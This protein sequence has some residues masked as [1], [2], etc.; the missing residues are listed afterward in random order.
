MFKNIFSEKEPRVDLALPEVLKTVSQKSLYLAGMAGMGIAFTSRMQ[1]LN[2]EGV[3]SEAQND[4]I[5]ENINELLT[6]AKQ[7]G[8][9]NGIL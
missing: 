6:Q 5:L 7:L 1:K 4:K 9:E 3:F 2:N 8:Q